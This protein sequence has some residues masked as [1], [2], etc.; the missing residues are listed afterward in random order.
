MYYKLEM[1][2][3]EAQ[4][5]SMSWLFGKGEDRVALLLQTLSLILSHPPHP[6]TL[7][8][9]EYSEKILI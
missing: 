9:K 6:L 5:K 3:D 1:L 4:V 7:S 2:E 8:K